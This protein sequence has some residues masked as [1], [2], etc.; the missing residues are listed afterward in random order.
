[1]MPTM[2]QETFHYDVGKD[3]NL[4]KFLNDELIDEIRLDF[5]DCVFGY[6]SKVE[7]FVWTQKVISSY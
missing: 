2:A 4:S 3:L 6:Y 7:S 5:L 1:M